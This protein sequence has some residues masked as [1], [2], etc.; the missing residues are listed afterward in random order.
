V[1]DLASLDYSAARDRI[2]SLIRET[3]LISEAVQTSDQG[4]AQGETP[5]LVKA[6]G[7]QVTGS[8][9]LRG[10]ANFLLSLDESQ[11]ARGLVACSSGNHGRA[12]AHAAAVLGIGATICVPDWVDELKLS[13]IRATGARVVLA[14]SSYDDA[15]DHACDLARSEGLTLVHPF[16]DPRIVEG[17]GTLGL[18]VADAVDSTP[19]VICPLSGGGLISGVAG[20]VRTAWPEARVVGVSAL[21][22]DTMARGIRAGH[23]V[24]APEAETIAEALSGGIGRPN[25]LTFSW[26]QEAV[27]VHCSV[28]EEAIRR[29]IRYAAEQLGLVVEGGGAVGLAALLNGALVD[30]VSQWTG[31]VVVILSGS[32][33]SPQRLAAVLKSSGPAERSHG[34]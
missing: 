21:N 25:R 10:A 20:A 2:R 23:P 9:K 33:I 19:L 13:R 34:V 31:P 28:S 4:G 17:Q 3:P 22:A 1:I 18:E 29:A 12:V 5:V 8:F 14:G 16:D 32:N 30:V 24:E 26:V 15:E 27:D 7:L 6:E 11:R